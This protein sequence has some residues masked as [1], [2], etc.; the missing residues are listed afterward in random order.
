MFLKRNTIMYIDLNLFQADWN[1]ALTIAAFSQIN[2]HKILKY[3]ILD[4]HVYIF[5]VE[6]KY[7]SQ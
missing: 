2:D 3:K 6:D 5:L 4:I 7:L 1:K